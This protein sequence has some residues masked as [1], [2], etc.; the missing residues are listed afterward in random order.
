[1]GSSQTIVPANPKLQI[2]KTMVPVQNAGKVKAQF[3][4]MTHQESQD[5]VAP[6]ALDTPSTS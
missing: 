2:T 4:V 3:F 5:T 1:M 6:D